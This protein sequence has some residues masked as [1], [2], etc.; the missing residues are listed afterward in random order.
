MAEFKINYKDIKSSYIIKGI[1]S[2][3][4]EKQKLKIIIYN[5]ELQN[6]CL[7]DIKDYKNISGKYIIGER[8]G[9]GKEY[10]V[11][12]NI[13]LYEGEYLNGK[14]N[15]KGKE[16]YKNNK[17]R[18]EGEYLNGKKWN[19]N[20]YNIKGDAEFEI[21]DGKG[22]I[23]EYDKFG[24][25]IF[26]GEYLN[27][28]KNGKGKEYIL[29]ENSNKLIYKG[30]YLHGRKNGKGKEYDYYGI[31]EYEGEYLDDYKNGKGKEYRKPYLT[32][33]PLKHKNFQIS[34]RRVKRYGI[35]IRY[36]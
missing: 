27:G 6:T 5:K 30:E 32:T 17:I 20:G 29:N 12:E 23:K 4:Y 18:F 14:R 25:L 9:K 13:L 36:S 19:G 34:V 3:L 28:E 21:K 11:N 8:N 2:Y 16:F 26:E 10:T 22:N 7:I 33:L 1:F 35:R 24:I 15:G 31:L